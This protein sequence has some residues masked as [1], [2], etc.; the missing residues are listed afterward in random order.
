MPDVLTQ[1][2]ATLT[3]LSVRHEADAALLA[4][5][6]AAG[7]PAAFAELVRRHGPTVLDVC[8]RMLGQAHDADDAF[9]ATFLVLARGARSVRKPEALSAWLYG[10]AVRVCRKA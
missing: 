4:R 8:R 9:Q 6:A 7:D 2:L 5:Y 1:S 10:A 3:R